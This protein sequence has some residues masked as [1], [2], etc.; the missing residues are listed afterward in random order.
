MKEDKRP[1]DQLTREL[2]QMR[3]KVVELETSKKE[4]ERTAE[5]LYKS[6]ERLRKI[7]RSFQ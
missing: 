6:E 2:E 1:T 7:F 5:A 4:W 3:S